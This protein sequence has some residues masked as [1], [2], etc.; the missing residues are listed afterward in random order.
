MTCAKKIPSDFAPPYKV[1]VWK[2]PGKRDV[3]E[4]CN[5]NYV[6]AVIESGTFKEGHAVAEL[7]VRAVNKEWSNAS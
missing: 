4:I 6:I 5:E 7:I 3:V 1:F 2:R